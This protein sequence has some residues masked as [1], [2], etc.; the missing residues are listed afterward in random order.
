VKSASISLATK[1]LAA[2]CFYVLSLASLAAALK[3]SNALAHLSYETLYA[4]SSLGSS[5]V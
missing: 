5:G 3:S 2:F 4:A 1:A